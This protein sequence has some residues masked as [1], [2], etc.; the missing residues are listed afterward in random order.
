ML[1]CPRACCATSPARCRPIGSPWSCAAAEQDVELVCGAAHLPPSNAAHRG[2]P[3]AALPLAR[4]RAWQLPTEAFV[5]DGLAA[6][7]AR[8]LT[9]TPAPCSPASCCPRPSQQLR[10]VATDSYRLSVKETALESPLQGSLEANVP[11]RALSE[12]V[13]HRPA[14][15]GGVARGERGPEPG[16]LRDRRGR[17]VLAPDRR[18]VP[19]LSPAAARGLDT[20]CAGPAPSSPTSCDASA[21]SRR[22]TRHCG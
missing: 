8:H 19:Q 7:P 21:C 18:T 11:A 1:S 15:P 14:G 2:L 6:S 16:D 10:M 3:H 12:L 5:A 4:R 13:A 17:P 22:R 20:S 9:T